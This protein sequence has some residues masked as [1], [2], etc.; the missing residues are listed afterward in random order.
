V[1]DTDIFQRAA[2]ISMLRLLFSGNPSYGNGPY[3]FTVFGIGTLDWQDG[4]GPTL[5]NVGGGYNQ[6]FAQLGVSGG[7]QNGLC[8]SQFAPCGVTFATSS[9]LIGAFPVPIPIVGAGLPGLLMAVAGFIGWRR[10]RCGVVKA[11]K[12]RFSFSTSH[13]E[14]SPSFPA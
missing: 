10:S 7:F 4:V 6:I 8:P 13:R 12:G 11:E 5:A 1:S 14:T 2:S 9:E 3:T